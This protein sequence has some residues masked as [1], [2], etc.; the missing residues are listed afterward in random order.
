MIEKTIASKKCF[1]NPSENASKCLIQPVDDH[2]LEGIENEFN[3]INN[4]CKM[5]F[6]LIAVRI[7]NWNNDLSPWEAPAVF[8][9]DDFGCG[10]GDAY[11]GKA[12]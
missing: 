9:K 2:D 3:T 4:N 8:G 11:Q 12:V 1:I 10:A 5:D 7:E 6:H